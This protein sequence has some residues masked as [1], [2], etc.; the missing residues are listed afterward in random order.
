MGSKS[1]S[2]IG[3]VSLVVALSFF[4]SIIWSRDSLIRTIWNWELAS[5]YVWPRIHILKLRSWV[6]ELLPLL[7]RRSSII[8]VITLNIVLLLFVAIIHLI[9]W[10]IIATRICWRE[11]LTVS[12]MLLLRSSPWLR[13]VKLLWLSVRR[14][15]LAIWTSWVVTLTIWISIHLWGIIWRLLSRALWIIRS[16]VHLV[17]VWTSIWARYSWRGSLIWRV[18]LLVCSV[19]VVHQI[20]VVQ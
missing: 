13:I 15:S 18:D 17:W 9:K 16:P 11:I 19:L 4:K 2:W 7:L 5:I 6:L 12:L 1:T 3:L 10:W 8:W 20:D 14:E